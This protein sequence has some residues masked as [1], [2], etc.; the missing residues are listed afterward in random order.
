[1]IEEPEMR[2]LFAAEAAEI[3]ERLENGLLALDRFS[4]KMSSSA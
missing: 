2:D 4:K 3:M 1:M